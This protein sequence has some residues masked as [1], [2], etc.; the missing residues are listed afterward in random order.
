MT[1][2]TTIIQKETATSGPTAQDSS[3]FGISL[4]GLLAAIL[5]MT[6]CTSH[7]LVVIT[8]MYDGIVKNEWGQLGTLTTVGEPLY[9]MSI[10]ALGF[11]FGQKVTK[12]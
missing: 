5:V 3:L 8:A 6:V 7:I 1:E 10:A 4:R 11:Y 12:P 9:S 2:E